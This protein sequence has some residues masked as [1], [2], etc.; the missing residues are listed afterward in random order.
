MRAHAPAPGGNVP[1]CPFVAAY[2]E[3]AE[4]VAVIDPFL[5]AVARFA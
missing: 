2:R 4:R 1:R 3:L 5:R